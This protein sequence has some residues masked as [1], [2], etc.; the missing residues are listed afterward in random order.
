MPAYGNE[1]AKTYH[2]YQVVFTTLFIA[3]WAL[4]QTLHA[5]NQDALIAE[6]S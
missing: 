2:T 6:S 3:C 4:G 5:E 1:K